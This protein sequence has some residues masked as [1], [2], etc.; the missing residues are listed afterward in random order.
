MNMELRLAEEFGSHL[1][2]GPKAAAYRSE[3]IEPLLLAPGDIVLDFAGIRNANSSFMNALLSGLIETH[4]EG[5]LEQIVFKGCNPT[6]KVL[7]ES[8]IDLGVQKFSRKA[9]V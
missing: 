1:A 9:I 3:K 7:V 2:D 4:G 6:V 8:A 5:V